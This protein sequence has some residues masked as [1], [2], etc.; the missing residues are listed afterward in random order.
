MPNENTTP[1]KRSPSQSLARS[2]RRLKTLDRLL[3][4]PKKRSPKHQKALRWA[5]GGGA[6]VFG[7][8]RGGFAFAK[9]VKHPGTK[10]I[11]FLANAL[12]AKLDIIED[13]FED[14]TADAFEDAGFKVD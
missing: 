14:A 11:P 5:K 13:I 1:P 8:A 10:A 9:E 12:E 6:V 2:L 7:P 4:L 3:S